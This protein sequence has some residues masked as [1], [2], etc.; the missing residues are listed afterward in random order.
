MWWRCSNEEASNEDAPGEEAVASEGQAS[1]YSMKTAVGIT[2]EVA[3]VAAWTAAY[4]ALSD[5]DGR[6]T[7]VAS[8]EN[9]NLL[10]VFEWTESHEAAKGFFTSDRFKAITDSIGVVGEIQATYYDV[11]DS[12]DQPPLGYIIGVGHEVNDYDAWKVKFD[13]DAESRSN[14][15][16]KFE[17]L[18]TDA[19]NP[20]MVY[21]M[22][23]TDDL[24]GAMAM[25]SSDELKQKMADAGVVGEPEVYIWGCQSEGCGCNGRRHIKYQ[26]LVYKTSVASGVF[27]FGTVKTILAETVKYQSFQV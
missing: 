26:T 19:D 11:K 21:I 8:N 4:E 22:F 5:P 7:V 14:S 25:M 10:T 18:S 12:D 6:I 16:M 23:S 13:E 27:L 20:N 17:A 3:D 15:G 9:A 1:K 2:H 24:D